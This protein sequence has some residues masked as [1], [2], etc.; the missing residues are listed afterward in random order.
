MITMPGRIEPTM[1]ARFMDGPYQRFQGT[2]MKHFLTMDTVD[3]L[4]RGFDQPDI[5]GTHLSGPKLDAS[6]S[7]L[8]ASQPFDKVFN[9]FASYKAA[10]SK[11]SFGNAQMIQIMSPSPVYPDMV[12]LPLMSMERCYGPWRSSDITGSAAEIYKDIGGKIEFEKDEALAP[13]NYAGYALM[14]EAGELQAKF[15]NSLLLF[16]ERGGFS[17]PDV[18]S[19]VSLCEALIEGG[20]LV[21]DI[22]VAISDTEIRSTYQMDLYTSRFGKLDKQKEIAL[23]KFARERQKMRDERNALIRKGMGKSRSQVNFIDEFDK[24]DSLINI[25]DSMSSKIPGP[26]TPTS[27]V[28]TATKVVSDRLDGENNV[29]ADTSYGTEGSTQSAENISNTIGTFADQKSA[30]TA[31]ADTAVSKITDEKAPI[32]DDSHHPKMAK[33]SPIGHIAANKN[34][35]YPIDNVPGKDTG[36]E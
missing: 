14:E 16:S 7:G 19:G 6:L 32:A 2:L 3:P 30:R 9:A 22:S 13:W 36:T 15:S 17:F 5:R 26:P 1:D 11:L 33:T 10:L 21:T 23:G 29:V 4:V 18:P 35:H 34:K 31:H 27:T 28:I 24:F 8:C 25:S 12:A 20:P